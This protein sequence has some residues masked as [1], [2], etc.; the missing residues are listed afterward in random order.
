MMPATS[1]SWERNWDIRNRKLRLLNKFET[2]VNIAETLHSEKVTKLNHEN[3]DLSSRLKEL[4]TLK[5]K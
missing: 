3:E 5:A 2:D 1:T 4:S